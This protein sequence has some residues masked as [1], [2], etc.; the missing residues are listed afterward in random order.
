MQGCDKTVTI[1]HRISKNGSDS[2]TCTV[3]HGASWCWQNKTTVNNGLQYS[4][5]LKCRIPLTCQP[6]G[7]QVAPGDK[8]VLGI[9]DEVSGKE[10]SALC[11]T[12]DGSTVLGVHNNNARSCSPHLYIEG[13]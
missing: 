13:A 9:L 1:V 10:F 8:V 5:L 2:Y 4:R 11:R 3:V 12:H 7:L 6:D